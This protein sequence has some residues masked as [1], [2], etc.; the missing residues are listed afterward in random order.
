MT[1]ENKKIDLNRRK[2]LLTATSI[3]GAI[4]VSAAGIPF[5]SSMLPSEK[6]KAAG[7]PVA[8]DIAGIKPGEIK[9]SEWRG[10]P[11]W[12]LN[13]SDEMI[14]KLDNNKELADPDLKVVSQQPKYCQNKTRSIK[15]NLLVVVGICTH[16]GCAPSPKLLPKGDMGTEW[17]GGF[18]C[19]C[20]G[21]KFD[22]AGRVFKGS[23]APTNLVVPP[24]KYIN[25][26]TVLIGEDPEGVA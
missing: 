25:E 9:T 16:L 8:V 1:D 7:A 11:V 19:P 14:K 2:F 13:R 4:G 26:Q 22:L 12:I 20:H 3:T 18:F 23:P 6:A 24:H 15:S 5:V 10:Q 17:E 21:S